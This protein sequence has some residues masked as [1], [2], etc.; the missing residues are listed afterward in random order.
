LFRLSRGGRLGRSGRCGRDGVVVLRPG[1]AH[2]R[3]IG[4]FALAW[5]GGGDAGATLKSG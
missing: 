2:L 1:D 5:L 3:V 4:A